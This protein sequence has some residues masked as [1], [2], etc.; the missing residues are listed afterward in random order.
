MVDLAAIPFYAALDARD[1]DSLGKL[2]H[3]LLKEAYSIHI[4]SSLPAIATIPVVTVE[5][6]A[7]YVGK[8]KAS[9]DKLVDIN[10][11]AQ[12]IVTNFIPAYPLV[13][14][15][16]NQPIKNNNTIKVE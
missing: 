2:L 8:A 15:A 13:T 10:R 7:I 11:R 4:S 5:S 3:P 14:L 6:F 16:Y 12:T 9:L 1:R